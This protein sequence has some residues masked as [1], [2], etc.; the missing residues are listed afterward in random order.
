MGDRKPSQ[1]LRHLRGLAP[2][3]PEDF[4]YTFWSSRQPPNIQTILVGQQECSLEPQPAV[5]TA[6]RRSLPRRRSLE[7][8][9]PPTTPHFCRRSRTS[10]ARW[11]HSAPSRTASTPALGT[12]PSAPGILARSQ[13][14]PTNQ[15]IPLPRRHRTHPLLVPSPFRGKSAEVYSTLRLP[16]AGKLTQQT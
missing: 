2:D 11:R 13:E 12:L 9:H 1:F 8:V 16:P 3:V 6:S 4:L 14:S 7:L 5:R 15:Q 10:P